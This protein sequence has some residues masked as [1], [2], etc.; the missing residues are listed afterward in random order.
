MTGLALPG[1]GSTRARAIAADKPPARA[2]AGLAGIL[3]AAIAAG[4]NN[5]V[6]ALALVD[7]RGALGFG[8]DDASWLTTAYSG[9]E[10][11]AM[12]FAAW[13]AITLSVR[14]FNL[15]MLGVSA[16]LAVVL[17]FIRDLDLLLAMR[18][19]QGLAGGTL[20]P[21]LMMAALK[22]LPPSIRLHGLAL[23]ALTATFAPHLS[24]WLA[25]R[26]TD[27]LFDWR[28][29]YWQI[30]PIS[31]MA[32]ALV[33]WGLPDEPIRAERFGEANWP[34]MACG[35]PGFGLLAVALD[36]GVRLE[37]FASPLI[38]VCLFAGV[39]LVGVFL[40]TEW[41]HP[42]PFM[43]LQI[44]ERRNL[45]LG[46]TLFLLVLVVLVSG[47]LLPMH[48]LATV[49]DYRP[50]QIAP[51][52]LIIALPQLVLGS[53]V[54]V[55]LYCKCVDARIVLAS[56]LALIA[57]ACFCGARLTSDWSG[58][59]FVLAQA[60]QA[61]GQPMAVVSMLFLSTSVV[62]P[63]EGPYVSGLINT[64]RAFGSLAGVAAVAELMVLR[65][66]FHAA[67]LSDHAALALAS[68]ADA[69]RPAQLMGV[70]GQQSL[71]LSIADA[72]LVLGVLAL[73]LV[74]IAL[75]LTYIPPPNLAA[76][77]VPSAPVSQQE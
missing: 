4:L 44:L 13:F 52:A 29:V 75:K 71:A 35:A 70:I 51:L 2:L 5:R 23:Y 27:A 57:L 21:L 69:Q 55:V 49:Q 36:Q 30:V 19:L 6:G 33:A 41:Y 72:Y 31:A 73:V 60:L 56:G 1:I 16:G 37:W 77:P 64:L 43:K 20:I 32:A 34:G 50:L 17:P 3:L 68:L 61:I 26:W 48:Y 8:L 59:Q 11:I 38:T 63:Q 39:A 40:L 15:W 9:G 28:W 24:T 66:R 45:W 46:F 18:F 47:S 12:P 42:A 54:A 62:Q 14:R 10:L 76:V 25:G 74:P 22:Y 65:G 7:V 67:V 53:A 58:D